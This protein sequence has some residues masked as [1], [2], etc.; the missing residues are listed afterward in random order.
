MF[1]KVSNGG[2]VDSLQVDSR[3]Q[4]TSNQ[5]GGSAS[6]SVVKGDYYIIV[7]SA[8]AGFA[9]GDGFQL[10]SGTMS[11]S[12]SAMLV[13]ATSSTITLRASSQWGLIALGCRISFN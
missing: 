12:G 9:S 6:R 10:I 3:L 4:F 8:N 7:G 5:Q 13:K 2:T 1:Y 11:A